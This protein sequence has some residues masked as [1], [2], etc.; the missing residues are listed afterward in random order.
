MCLVSANGMLAYM[1]EMSREAKVGDGWIGVFYSSCISCAEFLML[2]AY[3]RGGKFLYL[4][5]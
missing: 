4:L 1:L 3:G 5:C 2:K